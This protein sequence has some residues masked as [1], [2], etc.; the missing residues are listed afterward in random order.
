MLRIDGRQVSPL[1][2]LTKKN[3]PP[4]VVFMVAA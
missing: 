1:S 3:P 4:V 2:A